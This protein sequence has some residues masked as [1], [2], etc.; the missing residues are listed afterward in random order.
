MDVDNLNFNALT[1]VMLQKMQ[2]CAEQRFSMLFLRDAKLE[3]LLDEFSQSFALKICAYVAEEKLKEVSVSYPKDWVEAVK[4]RFSPQWLLKK[5]PVIYKT[6]VLKA[7]VLYPNIAFPKER[8]FLKL[9]KYVKG[10]P[11]L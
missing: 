9:D 2:F 10:G 8:H 6:E 3:W 7:S 4:E 11:L 1:E 5:Y